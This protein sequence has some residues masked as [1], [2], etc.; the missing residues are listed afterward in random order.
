[1]LC[2]KER[3]G[4]CRNWVDGECLKGFVVENCQQVGLMCFRSAVNDTYTEEVSNG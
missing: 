1:M 3:V 4:K 2:K